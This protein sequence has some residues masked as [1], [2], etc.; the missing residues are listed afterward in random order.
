MA[1][2]GLNSA[3]NIVINNGI[4]NKNEQGLQNQP[5][6]ALRHESHI[7]HVNSNDLDLNKNMKQDKS[8]YGSN[9]ANGYRDPVEFNPKYRFNDTDYFNHPHGDFHLCEVKIDNK[10]YRL[11]Y[12]LTCSR[13]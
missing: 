8:R 13:N 4:Q 6:Q 9:K 5:I 1:L 3:N 7:F 11:H 12:R 10:P 2:V